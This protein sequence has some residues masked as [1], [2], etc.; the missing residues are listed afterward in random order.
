MGKQIPHHQQFLPER[1][2]SRAR[3]VSEFEARAKE[4]LSPLSLVAV[5]NAMRAGHHLTEVLPL[6]PTFL[7]SFAERVNAKIVAICAG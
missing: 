5:C 7:L 4:A 1:N 2:A 3:R 6:F